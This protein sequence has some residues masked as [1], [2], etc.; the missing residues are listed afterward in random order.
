VD[1]GAL[2]VVA[3]LAVWLGWLVLFGT[4]A[5]S[6]GPAGIG[7]RIWQ[8]LLVG[9]AAELLVAVPM[10]LIVRQR[11]YCCAGMMT[12]LGIALGATVMFLALGPAVFVLCYRRYQQVYAR[13]FGDGDE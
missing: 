6:K 2:I 1:T 4:L 11:T 9:S 7:N 13:P 12:G 8:S 3:T 10:H 5:L